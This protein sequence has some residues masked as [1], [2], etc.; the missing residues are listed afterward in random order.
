MMC[1]NPLCGCIVQGNFCHKCGS[2]AISTSFSNTI[3][4]KGLLEDGSPCKLEINANRKFCN[5]CGTPEET[6][7]TL[8]GEFMP[9]QTQV[10]K[11]LME[12]VHVTHSSQ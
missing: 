12:A 8:S 7:I 5:N 2:K 6:V 11:K 1:S 4:C 10:V 3:Y 9:T